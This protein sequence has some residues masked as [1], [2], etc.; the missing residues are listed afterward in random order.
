[1]IVMAAMK[2]LVLV[3]VL[4]VVLVGG[5]LALADF[6]FDETRT[7]TRTVSEPLRA[8]VVN[9]DAG[10]VDLVPAGKRVQVR[11][12]QH[13]VL[14]KPKLE[15]VVKNGVLTLDSDCGAPV[16]RCY[17]DLRV[18]VPR[19]VTVTVVADSGDVDAREIDVRSA[20]IESD[21]GDVRL[22]LVGRQGLVW[23]HADSGRVDVI[24]ASARAVDAQTDSGD[25]AVDVFRQAPRRVVARSDSG[26]VQV[27]AR[28][29]AYAIEAH[30]DSGDVTITG[31]TR[32]DRAPR[33][34]EARSGSGDVAL[35]AR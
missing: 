29:G 34:I 21:S 27:I 25:V 2:K 12:T 4:L 5:G 8:I 10:D 13:Y 19:G 35:R 20:H 7:T 23:A 6:V 32:N 28:K 31:L 22:G 33:S 9:A 14:T 3:I 16:L 26:F 30:S 15:M 17:A 1:V 24:A 11:E 18:T